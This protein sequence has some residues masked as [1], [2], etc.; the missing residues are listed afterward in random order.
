M[1]AGGIVR[2]RKDNVGEMWDIWGD[3]RLV[4]MGLCL[5]LCVL[6]FQLCFYICRVVRYDICSSTSGSGMNLVCR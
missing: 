6:R 2:V 5:D 3:G 1:M 4:R